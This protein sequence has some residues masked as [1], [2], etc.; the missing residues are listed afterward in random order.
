MR[1]GHLA[2]MSCALVMALSLTAPADAEGP[3][4]GERGGSMWY[5]HGPGWGMG[6]FGRWGRGPD[7]M[8]ERVEGRLAFM[9]AE[10]KIT[11]A[12]TA[13]WNGFADAVRAAAKQHNER[14]K[15]I[16][17]SDERSKALPDRVDAQEQFMTARLEQ[18]KQVKAGLKGLYAVLS[19]EQKTEAD[20]M[21]I[22]MIGM[23]GGPGT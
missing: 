2:A 23:M 18:I 13:A 11:E 14:M 4:R 15:A 9:K 22:P 5:E 12:Q 16:Q 21:V 10:L 1:K 17:A 20:D 8:L 3:Q 19:G 7:M 6:M